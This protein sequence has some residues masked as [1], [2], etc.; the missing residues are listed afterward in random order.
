MNESIQYESSFKYLESSYPVSP[1]SML[2]EHDN[3]AS[4]LTGFD[5]ILSSTENIHY[6]TVLIEYLLKICEKS[7]PN[8]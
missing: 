8:Y 6:L 7:V 3:R 5:E 1:S 4:K 2:V